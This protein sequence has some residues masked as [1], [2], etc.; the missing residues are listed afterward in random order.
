MK[1]EIEFIK[2]IRARALTGGR[3][4]VTG[5]GDDAA[6]L[7][8]DSGRYLL[9]AADMLSEGTHFCLKKTTFNKIGR[10]AVAV[11]IS[12]IA[13][14]GGVPKYITV[15]IALPA[16]VTKRN[17]NN[18]YDGIF[19]ICG[20][21]GISLV[22][23]DTIRSD[24]LIIDVS[25][26]GFV[27]KKRL[28]SRGGAKEDDI[29]LVT[30]PLADARKTHLDFIPRL[31]EARFLTEK[32]KVTSMIDI[33]DGISPDVNRICGESGV[34]CRIY[35]EAIPLSGKLNMEDVL[36][37]GENFELLFTMSP[38]EARRLFLDLGK[39]DLKKVFF[40]IGEIT[41]KNKG[42]CLVA[43]EGVLKKLKMKGYRHM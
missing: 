16:R 21:Y 29:V 25:M 20:Q 35:K 31:K 19:E 14:M 6:V 30:G 38:K 37:Y 39:R 13:A 4:I 11:N 1:R 9:W 24:K 40:V 7:Q 27:E 8:Y 3:G 33:S 2:N 26:I 41:R 42:M 34:G 32:Y 28:V 23:G 5:I 15:S 36:Y 18:I 12:D 22:G 10:K 43:E 17:L